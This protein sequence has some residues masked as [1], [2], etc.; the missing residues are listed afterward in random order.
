MFLREEGGVDPRVSTVRK[1]TSKG[2]GFVG[3]GATPT[4]AASHKFVF[5]RRMPGIIP[6]R[7]F[8]QREHYFAFVFPSE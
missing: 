6:E 1:A 7:L 3:V 2:T 5:C 8:Q 4:N